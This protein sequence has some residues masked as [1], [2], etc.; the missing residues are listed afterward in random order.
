M[1]SND[2]KKVLAGVGLAT[3]M[4]GGVVAFTAQPALSA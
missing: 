2:L 3:L 4:T 1:Q